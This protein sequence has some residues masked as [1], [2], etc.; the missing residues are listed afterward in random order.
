LAEKSYHEELLGGLTPLDDLADLPG[1]WE[2]LQQ[3]ILN[4]G[5]RP[6][7]RTNLPSTAS[8][9]DW[10]AVL[11]VAMDQLI[12]CDKRVRHH[13]LSAAQGRSIFS[14]FSNFIKGKDWA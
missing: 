6:A 5:G 12:S 1:L 2:S 13:G 4:A 11:A 10:D 14:R 8:L 3:G 7:A 9:S